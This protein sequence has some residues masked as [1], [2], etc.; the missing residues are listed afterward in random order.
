MAKYKDLTNKQVGNLTV[1]KLSE[2]KFDNNGTTKLWECQCKCGKIIYKSARLLNES[3]KTEKVLSCGCS[4]YKDYVGKRFGDYVVKKFVTSLKNNKLWLCE[5]ICGD[6]DIKSSKYLS[7]CKYACPKIKKENNAIRSKLKQLFQ[8][9]KSR[10][11]NSN[12]P[13]YKYYGER[14]IVIYS[15]WLK[16]TNKFV[17]WALANGYDKNLQIDRIDND[18]NYEPDNCRWVNRLIQANN[19]RNNIKIKYNNQI[20]SLRE[21]CRELN[22]PYRK[23]HKRLT[24]YKWSVEKCFDKK[25]RVGF[26]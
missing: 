7:R 11:Y 26:V 18:G 16:D 6:L 8:K 14:G 3:I 20:K 22:L 4:S 25:E 15:E 17:D 19:K 2:D 21:W 9:I 24:L 5:C 13:H 23:T 12:D 1:L 10:C